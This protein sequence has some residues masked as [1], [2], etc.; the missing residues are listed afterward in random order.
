[1]PWRESVTSS[2]GCSSPKATKRRDLVFKSLVS[3]PYSR[4][5]SNARSVP[6]LQRTSLD[7]LGIYYGRHRSLCCV[8]SPLRTM[9]NPIVLGLRPLTRYAVR[10]V[11]CFSQARPA[12]NFWWRSPPPP[13]RHAVRSGFPLSRRK[14]ANAE[15]PCRSTAFSGLMSRSSCCNTI[16]EGRASSSLSSLRTWCLHHRLD[17]GGPRKSWDLALW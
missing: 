11:C 1:M 15:S 13:L 4:R 9:A 3:V 8:A 16:T 7:I 14:R 10:A 6:S 5:P 12:R 2:F 17:T